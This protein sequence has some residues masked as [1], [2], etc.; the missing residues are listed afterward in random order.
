MY[1]CEVSPWSDWAECATPEKGSCGMGTQRREREV[2]CDWSTPAT[3]LIAHWLRGD[4]AREQR[5]RVVPGP[6]PDQ[7]SCGWLG[8]G[9]V[10]TM[11]TSDWS[12][13]CHVACPDIAA[14]MPKIDARRLDGKKHR[15]SS[16]LRGSWG[17]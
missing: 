9:H 3:I 10:T 16:A 4:A 15:T 12:R 5:R 17:Y 1:D 14:T 13:V 7:V 2:S 11:L 6:A 8:A